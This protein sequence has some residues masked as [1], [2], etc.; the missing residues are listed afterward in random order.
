MNAVIKTIPGKD[1]AKQEESQADP[2]DL[3]PSFW[4]RKSEAQKRD[5]SPCFINPTRHIPILLCPPVPPWPSAQPQRLSGYCWHIDHHM[6]H[7]PSEVIS[8]NTNS[9]RG[10]PNR[11]GHLC[12]PDSQWAFG[13]Q[14]T[15]EGLSPLIRGKGRR[16]ECVGRHLQG[17]R[18]P[19]RFS[20]SG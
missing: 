5:R 14:S 8:P 15:R 19:N 2:P 20:C 18:N 6:P 11:R 16:L 3:H 12:W 13:W 4:S 9:H 10:F 17:G 7:R 1:G